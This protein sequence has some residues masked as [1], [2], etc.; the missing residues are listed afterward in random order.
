MAM[1][2]GSRRR[3]QSRQMV[4]GFT[5]VE[6]LVVI[7]IIAL[8]LGFLLPALGSVRESARGIVC[9]ANI[10]QFLTAMQTYEA[11]NKG[12]LIG[13]P[14]SSGKKLL[15]DPRAMTMPALEVNGDAS[16]PF[17][18]AGPMA[19][20]Y[21][22][23][24]PNAPRERDERFALTS[25]GGIG[26]T[27][28]DASGSYG[29]FACPTNSQISV[30][31]DGATQPNGVSGT[32]F[33]PQ[34]STSYTTSRDILWFSG[35]QDNAFVPSWATNDD[36]FWGNDEAGTCWMGGGVANDV[37]LPGG[38]KGE[39]YRARIDR[40]GTSLSSKVFI[41]DGTRFQQAGLSFIDHDVQGTGA[42]GGA[43]SDPGPW[44]VGFSRAY[45]FGRNN[46][47]QDMS[48]NSFRH[49][50]REVEKGNVGWFDGHVTTESL[51]DMRRP[52]FF[53]PT[54]SR[55]SKDAIWDVI[56]EEY[57]VSGG[58]F[59]FGGEVTVD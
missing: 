56:L 43:F 51:D 31:F 24:N 35:P 58:R 38:A 3:T 37:T 41:A 33:Q 19:F 39:G 29:V 48:K 21:M 30:P 54:A 28:R 45:P 4:H 1:K 17:D 6:L 16:Q 22:G 53:L 27:A 49:G 52:E 59:G 8:L 5:L 55:V 12:E 47:G 26:G 11:E 57:E 50:G 7:S 2:M 34:L 20:G 9:G 10:K 13:S 40:V 42:F 14:G 25:G 32:A 23:D 18:W 15:N 46:A 36:Q 44:N